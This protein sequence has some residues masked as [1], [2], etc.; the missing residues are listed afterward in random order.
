MNK[1]NP[2]TGLD[3]PW[4]FQQVE[5]HRFQD[6]RY[7]K[8]V[9]LIALHTGRL[10]PQEIFL[11]LISARDWVDCRVIVGLEGLRQWKIPMKPSGIEPAPCRLVA[12]CLNHLRHRVPLFS[13]KEVVNMVNE[14]F[15]EVRF[16]YLRQIISPKT[17]IHTY[18]NACIH[19]HIIYTY[20]HTYI[21]HT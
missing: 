17:Y 19:K 20:M 14:A 2:F 6:N 21:M 16:K 12:Q 3:R 4:G 13:D 18:M 10:Y 1:S 7:M 5:A 9:R 8:V 15:Y 11:V